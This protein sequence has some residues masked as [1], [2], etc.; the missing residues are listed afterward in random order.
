MLFCI[1]I[2]HLSFKYSQFQNIEPYGASS[3][4]GQ[5]EPKEQKSNSAFK[6]SLASKS[7]G[8]GLMTS[9][10]QSLSPDYE[11]KEIKNIYIDSKS[12][13]FVCKEGSC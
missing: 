9:N 12:S 3:V 4:T 8:A 13:S 7:F 6:N 10:L 11:T 2:T 5:K 1:T